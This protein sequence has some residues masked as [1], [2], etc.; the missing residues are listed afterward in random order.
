MNDAGMFQSPNA[1]V[2]PSLSSTC[3]HGPF[4]KRSIVS[5]TGMPSVLCIRLRK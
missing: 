3:S 1:C 4:V 5:D 2:T